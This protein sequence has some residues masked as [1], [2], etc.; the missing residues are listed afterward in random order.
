MHAAHNRRQFNIIE[1]E[2]E[3]RYAVSNDTQVIDK[4][5]LVKYTAGEPG[6]IEREFFPL[7][8]YR[9]TS[10]NFSRA[11]GLRVLKVQ[12]HLFCWQKLSF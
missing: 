9:R 8:R 11:P 7:V 4:G 10:R 5:D 2:G 12:A 3:I 1:Q 6:K